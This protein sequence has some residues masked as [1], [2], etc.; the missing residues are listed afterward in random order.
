MARHVGWP[1]CRVS[2]GDPS[3]AFVPVGQVLARVGLRELL[4]AARQD[5]GATSR[6]T[7]REWDVPAEDRGHLALFILMGQS[8]MSGRGALDA[9]EAPQ[10]HSSI[11]SFNKDYRWYPAREPLGTMPNEVDWIATDGGTGVGPGLAFARSLVAQEPALKIGLIPCARGA[12]SIEEWQP[13]GGQNT[14]YGACLKRVRAASSY[15]EV[16]GV[17]FSQGESDA[18]DPALYAGRTLSAGTW[19]AKFETLVLALRS[20]L[21]QS[22]LPVLFAQLG[23]YTG[24]G[25]PYWSDVK[26]QQARVHLPRVTMIQ[27]DDLVLGSDAH[28][29]TASNVEIGRRFAAAHGPNKIGGRRLG[30][31]SLRDALDL[32]LVL[33]LVRTR[34]VV[35]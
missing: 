18:D 3:P 1:H 6:L 2:A 9:P 22:E 7:L 25:L 5:D 32:P 28:F 17:L 23:T 19:A 33:V 16:A 15:G 26:S 35:L 20:D 4:P 14:L 13:G 12:S 21:G 8:N 24:D 29:G 10:P 11:Y 30:L 34:V 27:T 31:P